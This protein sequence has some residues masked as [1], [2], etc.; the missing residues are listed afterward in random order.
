VY[1]LRRLLK[2]GT[3]ADSMGAYVPAMAAQKMLGLFR[4][5]VFT[6]LMKEAQ[7]EYG[8]WGLGMMFFTLAAP[9]MT[10]GSEHG[11]VRYLSFYEA[12]G[13]LQAFYVQVRKRV[14][15]CAVAM[16]AAGVFAAP[17]IT[18]L[19]IAFRTE[20]ARSSSAE[21]MHVCLAAVA[22]AFLISLQG[23]MINFMVG[24]RAY[25]LASAVELLFSAV[26]TVFGIGTLL[27][28][29]TSLAIL[30]AHLA[31]LL[32]SLVVGISLLHLGVTRLLSRDES[33]VRRALADRTI[34]STPLPETEEITAA[35][36]QPVLPAPADAEVGRLPDFARIV[37]FGLVVMLGNFLWLAAQYVSFFVTYLRYGEKDAGLFLPFLQLS[38]P[39][40]FLANAAWAVIFTHVARRYEG[41]QKQTAMFVLEAGYKAV[42]M[43]MMTLTVAIYAA[44]PLWV[45]L[46]HGSYRQGLPAIGGLLTFFQVVIHLAVLTIIAKLREQPWVIA[47]AAVAGIAANAL[48]AA[49][50]TARGA[51]APEGPAWAAGVGMYVG[52]GLVTMVYFL[53]NRIRLHTGTYFVLACPVLLLAAKL[54]PLWAVAAIWAAICA[55][56]MFTPAM[57]T[58]RE[59]QLLT[60]SLERI[61]RLARRLIGKC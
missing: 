31:S 30:L 2:V 7:A 58:D 14:V 22:N 46:V 54:V 4:V 15:I 39:T 47:I 34:I 33:A 9:L 6:Y 5:L 56:A 51:F 17:L 59:K 57:F 13:Q 38:Q 3:V 27:I 29:Q 41:N 25:R 10:F 37:K 50:W 18:R 42:A 35:T 32:V 60:A 1:L 44:S 55:V 53:G 12:R 36:V 52:A 21:I 26:F 19:L 40:L 20:A 48:L 45:R 24:M 23:N 16:L 28:V 11:L 61:L 43:V 49:W 8:L